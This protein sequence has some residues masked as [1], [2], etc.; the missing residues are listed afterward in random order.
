MKNHNLLSKNETA[1]TLLILTISLI[2]T[3]QGLTKFS[4]Q[5]T[6]DIYKKTDYKQRSLV[7]ASTTFTSYATDC[8]TCGSAHSN[9]NYC[10]N[11]N[12]VGYCCMIGDTTTAQCQ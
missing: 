6:N 10:N 1:L 7:A 5:I 11:N 12:V 2:A 3:S 8:Y 9:A 4:E